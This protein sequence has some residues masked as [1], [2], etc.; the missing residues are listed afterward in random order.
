MVVMLDSQKT[1]DKDEGNQG[2]GGRCHREEPLVTLFM[3]SS[4][5]LICGLTG[6]AVK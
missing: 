3:I 4:R 1:G 5:Q 6:G 2:D